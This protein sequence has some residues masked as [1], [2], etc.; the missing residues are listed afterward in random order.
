MNREAG[1]GAALGL[2]ARITLSLQQRIE[3]SNREK[4]TA[5]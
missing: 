1:H 2:P 4:L 3:I 5:I